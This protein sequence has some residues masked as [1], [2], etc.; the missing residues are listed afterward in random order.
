MSDE[1]QDNQL[2]VSGNAQN[3]RNV[4]KKKVNNTGYSAKNIGYGYTSGGYDYGTYVY[5][6]CDMRCGYSNQLSTPD[7]AAAVF[8][9]LIVFITCGLCAQCS[10]KEEISK[11]HIELQEAI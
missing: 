5:G 4:L 10:R 2:S 11:S 3:Y 6:G 1:A 9:C 7:V 8:G